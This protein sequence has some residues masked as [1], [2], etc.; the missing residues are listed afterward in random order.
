MTPFLSL[1]FLINHP[2]KDDVIIIMQS[3]KKQFIISNQND[4]NLFFKL[5][6]LKL[7]TSRQTDNSTEFHTFVIIVFIDPNTKYTISDSRIIH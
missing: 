5:R 2:G 4:R 6:H 1:F 7:R 3:C